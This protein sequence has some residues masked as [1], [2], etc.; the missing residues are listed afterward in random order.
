MQRET[1]SSFILLNLWHVS[2]KHHTRPPISI[3]PSLHR[4][5]YK[6]AILLMMSQSQ[7]RVSGKRRQ[8]DSLDS[9]KSHLSVV[10]GK[11]RTQHTCITMAV[12]CT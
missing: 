5:Q 1:H 12:A 11:K 2:E 3:E 7:L 10:G 9:S 4:T 6:T 8:T